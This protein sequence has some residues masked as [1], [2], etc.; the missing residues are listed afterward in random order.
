MNHRHIENYKHAQWEL[1]VAHAAQV[2]MKPCQ[3]I[4]LQQVLSIIQTGSH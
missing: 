3:V 1:Q 2:Q 4:H